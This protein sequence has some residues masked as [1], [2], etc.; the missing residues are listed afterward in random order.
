MSCFGLSLS[1]RHK[2]PLNLFRTKNVII[3]KLL[4]FKITPSEMAKSSD[5]RI[6]I[7][8]LLPRKNSLKSMSPN[9]RKSNL[10]HFCLTE[11]TEVLAIIIDIEA[12]N[13]FVARRKKREAVKNDDN[14]VDDKLVERLEEDFYLNDNDGNEK[15][16]RVVEEENVVVVKKPS[17]TQPKKLIDVRKVIAARNIAE[18]SINIDDDVYGINAD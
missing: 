9:C 10:H 5:D 15:F 18:T 6:T 17:P 3:Q 7:S 1:S 2:L 13:Y 12:Y 8:K 11:V 14:E 16:V 4:Q